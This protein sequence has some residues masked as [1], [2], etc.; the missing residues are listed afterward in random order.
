MSNPSLK[1]Q[2]QAV[3][4]KLAG[5]AEKK[6]HMSKK[7]KS[8]V[9][10]Y[11]QYG[12]ELLKAHFPF[13][14]KDHSEI[15]PLKIGIKQ[16]LVKRLGSLEDIIINDKACMVKS[17]NYYVNTTA[18][19]KRVV[20]GSPRIDLDGNAIGAVTAEEAGYSEQRRQNKQ[21]ARVQT[22]VTENN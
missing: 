10:E 16:D 1:E 3:A 18:Y 4:F 15:Q 9:L 14:F 5:P 22:L 8:A 13:C 12:V 19:H 21:Q 17:L 6:K 2:L 20:V 11:L 7:Q